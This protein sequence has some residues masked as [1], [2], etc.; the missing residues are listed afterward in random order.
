MIYDHIKNIG[1]YKGLSPALDEALDFVAVASPAMETGTV[2]LGHGVKA[3]ASEYVTKAVEPR[4][5]E[6]HLDYADVQYLLSGEETIKCCPLEGLRESVPYDAAK[7]CVR[8]AEEGD[9]R[10]AGLR[11][12]G[13]YFAVVFPDDAH[14][15]GLAC[16]EPAAVRKLVMK[17]PVK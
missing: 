17:V 1:L 3:I 13:G 7:D 15:P 14:I 9:D 10:A 12:G 2:M 6:A 8:Y 5:Y 4:G 16:G 11:L